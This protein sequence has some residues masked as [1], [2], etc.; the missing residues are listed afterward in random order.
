MALSPK[1]ATKATSVSVNR[2][3]WYSGEVSTTAHLAGQIDNVNRRL[4]DRR[5]RQFNTSFRPSGPS[6]AEEVFQTDWL[7]TEECVAE[8]GYD[9]GP[10]KA[11][12][13]YQWAYQPSLELESTLELQERLQRSIRHYENCHKAMCIAALRWHQLMQDVHHS[14]QIR[15]MFMDMQMVR[16]L[17]G[18]DSH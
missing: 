4:E 17:S 2:T 1:Y 5:A 16:K 7:E 15:K 11:V 8:D 6:L 9:D 13:E 3:G 10:V 14:E 18:Y 12:D